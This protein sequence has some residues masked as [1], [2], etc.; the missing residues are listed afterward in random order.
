[1][2]EILFHERIHITQRKE[3]KINKFN[4]FTSLSDKLGYIYY[5]TKY[6]QF[7]YKSNV[8]IQKFYINS[9]L[10]FS[11]NS[12]SVK[13]CSFISCNIAVKLPVP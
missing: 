10:I 1:M 12:S 4:I 9:F 5:D 13:S 7:I 8:Y 11:I 3:G 2:S 6:P